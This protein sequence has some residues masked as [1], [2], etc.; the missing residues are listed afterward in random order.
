MFT[1]VLSNISKLFAKHN[2]M[3]SENLICE[4]ANENNIYLKF[5]LLK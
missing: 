5:K 2:R 1:V 4:N 3:E